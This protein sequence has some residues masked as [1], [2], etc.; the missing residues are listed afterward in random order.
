[1]SL[2]TPRRSALLAGQAQLVLRDGKRFGPRRHGLQAPQ[3]ANSLDV[4]FLH[5]HREMVTKTDEAELELIEQRFGRRRWKIGPT[6][7][8]HDQPLLGEEPLAQLP[9]P[10]RHDQF[11]QLVHAELT[12]PFRG[13]V[14]KKLVTRRRDLLAKPVDKRTE[15]LI[16]PT[17]ASLRKF[18]LVVP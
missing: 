10:F 4:Q 17:S 9:M 12:R 8:L 16:V 7:P 15:L 13:G 6:Q 14:A 2:V 3:T 5:D 11:V 1:R 18:T